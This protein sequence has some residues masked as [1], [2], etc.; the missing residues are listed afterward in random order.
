MSLVGE[1]FAAVDTFSCVENY[2]NE[3]DV[4]VEWSTRCVT[5]ATSNRPVSSG[6]SGDEKTA[7][8][9]ESCKRGESSIRLK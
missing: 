8:K 7:S 1:E 5:T 6:N 3:E 4:E 2:G 9:H